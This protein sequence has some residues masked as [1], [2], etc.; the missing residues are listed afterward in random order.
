MKFTQEQFKKIV[1]AWEQGFDYVKA[2]E[3]V[4]KTVQSFNIPDT[5]FQKVAKA[6]ALANPETRELVYDKYVEKEKRHVWRLKT[7]NDMV[8]SRAYDN[9][10]L[11]KQPTLNKEFTEAEIEK[12]P[13]KP[14]WFD[15]RSK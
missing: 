4:E 7:D 10:Y 2:T 8:V 1:E 12:S 6:L 5:S 15:K 3:A 14:E 11:D 9:W 13:F